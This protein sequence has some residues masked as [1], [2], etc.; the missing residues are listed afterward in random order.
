M[1]LIKSPSKTITWLRHF[2]GMYYSQSFNYTN[3][4]TY[5]IKMK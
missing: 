3:N 2:T 4:N 1:I 5:K